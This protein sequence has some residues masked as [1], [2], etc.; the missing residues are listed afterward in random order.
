MSPESGRVYV[1]ISSLARWTGPSAGI[2]RVER[3]LA[4]WARNNLDRA[5]FVIFDPVNRSYRAVKEGWLDAILGGDAV[6]NFWGL[7]DA[8]RLKVRHSD[9]IPALIRPLMMWV[10]QVR[11]S[12][13]YSLE[14]IRLS[15]PRIQFVKAAQKLQGALMSEKY[16]RL[17]THDQW[18]RRAFVPFDMAAGEVVEMRPLDILVC[19]GSAWLHSDI[20]EIRKLKVRHGFKL[21][22][23]CFDI[24]PLMFPKF[25]RTHDVEAFRRHYHVAFPTADIVVFSARQIEKDAL[26]YCAA[27]GLAIGETCVVPLGADAVAQMGK[28][29]SP[30]PAR[31]EGGRFAL[32]VSTIEPRKGHRLLYEVWLRLLAEGVPQKAG[33]RLVFVGRSG[34]LVDDLMRLLRRDARIAGSL[35]LLPYVEDRELKALYEGAAFCLYPSLYEGYGLPIIEAFFHGKA[36]LA[37]T[38]GAI[39][40]VIG[41]FSPCLD[42]A[43]PEAWY[44]MMKQ[45]ILEPGARYPYEEAIRKRFRHPSWHE[46]AAR[47]F[48]EILA[49]M[50]VTHE[51]Q[52]GRD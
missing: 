36:V 24:I 12:L 11:R 40:E 49:Y 52:T 20:E 37:S 41:E 44:R 38:G 16:R 6:V 5:E 33:F 3:Q 51:R 45:W 9:R 8:V 14:R 17:M 30:L 47:F 27:R 50:K 34:W 1:D 7:P 4:L 31:L 43:D 35:I 15:S 10:L 29:G 32:F 46:A 19:A 21:A 42:P 39:P 2:A 18:Y 13:L 22:I 25:F 26:A 48:K 23:L 28:N